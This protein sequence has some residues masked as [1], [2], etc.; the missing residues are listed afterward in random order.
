MPG[1]NFMY[2]SNVVRPGDQ[3]DRNINPNLAPVFGGTAGGVGA[4][5]PARLNRETDFW[6]HGREPRNGGDVVSYAAS[7][8]ESTQK[9]PRPVTRVTGRGFVSSRIG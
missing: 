4:A 6:A 7:R 1:Y 8:G 2:W 9:K 3:I 5:A